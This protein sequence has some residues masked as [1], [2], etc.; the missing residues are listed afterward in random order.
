MIF[1]SGFRLEGVGKAK[2]LQ[3]GSGGFPRPGQPGKI[4]NP[5]IKVAQ[6]KCWLSILL[7]DA[8]KDKSSCIK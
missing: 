6:S 3:N 5:V 1:Y 7:K 4:F 2:I 8:T